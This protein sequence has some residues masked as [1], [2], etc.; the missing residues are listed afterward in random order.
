MKRTAFNVIVSILLILMSLV[1]IAGGALGGVEWYILKSAKDNLGDMI[2][3]ID[4]LDEAITLLQDNE[5]IYAEGVE[6][7]FEGDEKLLEGR[8][9]IDNGKYV[10]SDGRSKMAEAQK[11]YDDAEA[12][13]KDAKAQYAVAEAKMEEA[14]PAYE[15]GKE[16]VAQLEQLQ[17]Y[18]DTYARFKSGV[19]DRI[20]GFPSVDAWFVAIVVPAAA[21]RGIYLPNDIN[22]FSQTMGQQIAEANAKLA[23]YEAAD[24]EM[25]KSKAEIQKAENELAE[26][27]KQLDEG[28]STID[29]GASQLAYAE[30]Q[31]D[32]AAKVV[33]DGKASLDEFQAAVDTVR[34]A[35][36]TCFEMEPICKRNGDVAVKG[37]EARF[38]EGFDIYLHNDEGK[39]LALE[40]GEPRLDYDKCRQVTQAF[41][42]YVSDYEKDLGR[43]MVVRF[44]LALGLILSGIFGICA[45]I[46]ALRG[47][48][49][50]VK[51]S[52]ILF[53][54]LM[55]LNVFGIFVGYTNFAHPHGE[56]NFQGTVPAFAM[57]LLTIAAF[58]FMLAVKAGHKKAVKAELEGVKNQLPREEN[59]AAYAAVFSEVL[60]TDAPDEEPTADEEPEA[61]ELPEPVIKPEAEQMTEKEKA[62]EST[63][64][65]LENAQ[66]E[67]DEALRRYYELKNRTKK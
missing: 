13:L 48:E 66:K 18:V 49:R 20:P 55:V 38:D 29:N 41:R 40:N 33:E 61:L 62:I 2:E 34:E 43:E 26:A 37:V 51:R 45:A 9:Q 64:S 14:R 65:A 17:P 22:Q 52:K 5:E 16:A 44:V 50:A 10:I 4:K 32:D 27:K 42:F 11:I 23:E 57:W 46:S 12:Q 24:A 8:R 35:V 30:S 58:V 67:Y 19:L 7:C 59:E 31:L 56:E 63:Q 60:G 28:Y 36:V 53:A 3:P 39:I 54:A 6:A 15:E 1:G 21:S 47:R 25:K